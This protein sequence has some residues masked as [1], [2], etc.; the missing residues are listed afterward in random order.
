MQAKNG[1]ATRSGKRRTKVKDLPDKEKEVTAAEAK[2]IKGG[3]DWESPTVGKP[4]PPQH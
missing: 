1:K 2:K 4:K 3:D